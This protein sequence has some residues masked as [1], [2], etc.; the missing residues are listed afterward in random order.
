MNLKELEEF[1]KE[2]EPCPSCED[3]IVR[4]FDKTS[5]QCDRC[6]FMAFKTE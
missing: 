1:K 2:M 3:G 6:A 5:A 4:P